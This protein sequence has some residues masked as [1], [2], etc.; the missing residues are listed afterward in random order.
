MALAPVIDVHTHM[1]TK[2]WLALLERLGVGVA[3]R[4]VA[5]VLQLAK[6]ILGHDPP[7]KWGQ[8]PFFSFAKE[9]QLRKIGSV[10]I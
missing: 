2:E 5:A 6:F 4:L 8:T 9:V 1:L 7:P 10:P 3:H